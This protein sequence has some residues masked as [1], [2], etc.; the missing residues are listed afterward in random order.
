MPR[1]RAAIAVKLRH[2]NRNDVRVAQGVHELSGALAID[3][4]GTTRLPQ[5]ARTRER[6]GRQASLAV[7]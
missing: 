5:N 7:E 3:E 6:L 4:D 2:A 1:D